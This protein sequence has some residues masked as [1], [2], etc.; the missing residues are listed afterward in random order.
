MMKCFFLLLLFC[1]LSFLTK[2]EEPKNQQ[3][4]V[5]YIPRENKINLP[6]L[7]DLP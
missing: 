3:A 5:E 1:A 2:S 6:A 4:G 7:N